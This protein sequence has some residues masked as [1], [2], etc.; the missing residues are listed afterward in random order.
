M[1]C[2]PHDLIDE[3]HIGNRL[4]GVAVAEA[5]AVSEEYL[6]VIVE[7]IEARHPGL[8]GCFMTDLEDRAI[9]VN[10]RLHGNEV[11]FFFVLL[12]GVSA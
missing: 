8:T 9:L 2:D 5:R 6:I 4:E 12:N 1:G 3:R 10:E 11:S 7:W